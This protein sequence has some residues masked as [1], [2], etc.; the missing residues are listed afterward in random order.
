MP[1]PPR[2]GGEDRQGERQRIARPHWFA[3]LP[4]PPEGGEEDREED[5]EEDEAGRMADGRGAALLLVAVCWSIGGE[6]VAIASPRGGRGGR[7][8]LALGDGV[9]G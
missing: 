6:A 1:R 5:R 4:S 7:P 2:Q 9:T 8:S 3:A